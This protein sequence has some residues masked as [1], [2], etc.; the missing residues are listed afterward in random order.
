MIAV[1][2]WALITFFAGF[3][4]SLVVMLMFRA[5]LGIGESVNTPATNKTIKKWFPLNE[6]GRASSIWNAATAGAPVVAFP[7]IAWLIAEFGW[8]GSFYILGVV[9]LIPLIFLGKYLYDSPK[10]S[11]NIGPEELAF[12]EANTEDSNV[13]T[14]IDWS[15]LKSSTFW[16]AAFGYSMVM[17][18]LYGLLS[19]MPVYLS[20]TL[21]FSWAAMGALS[22]LHYAFAIVGSLV[23]GWLVD[24]VKMKANVSNVA[25][26]LAG[27]CI[28]MGINFQSSIAV[29]I[30]LS[31]ATGLAMVS[32]PVWFVMILNDVKGSAMATGA[33]FF[34][35]CGYIASSV[36]PLVVGVLAA[37]LGLAGGFV[38]LIGALAL[39]LFAGI[40]MNMKQKSQ[41]AA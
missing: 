27:I 32:I 25:I 36:T 22:S 16:L 1:L 4:N 21:G 39:C 35:G 33:G 9:G 38:A 40:L 3:V 12:I 26:I 41:M 5:F 29:A 13:E 30:T 18:M 10:E 15:F 28:Y 6:R 19:W 20:E 31:V 37:K 23:S 34:N 14:K 7:I 17:A 11:P 2:L 8:R 24:R